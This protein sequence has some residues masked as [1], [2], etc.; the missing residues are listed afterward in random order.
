MDNP[1]FCC[2]GARFSATLLPQGVLPGEGRPARRTAAPGVEPEAQKQQG[3]H[4]QLQR[5]ADR[6]A[7]LQGT[8]LT[9]PLVRVAVLLS[10]DTK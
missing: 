6:A 10:I 4:V 2:G 3:G 9:H 7:A 1:W 5:D 8:L